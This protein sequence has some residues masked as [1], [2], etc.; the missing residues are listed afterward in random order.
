MK[1]KCYGVEEVKVLKGEEEEGD[2]EEVRKEMREEWDDW[3]K[4]KVMIMRD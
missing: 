2:V 4:E 3:E 1:E